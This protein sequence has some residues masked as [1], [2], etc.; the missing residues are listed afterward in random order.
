MTRSVVFKTPGK[1]D[2]RSITKF[3][4]NAKPATETPIGYFGTGLKYAVAILA[5][6]RIPMTFYIDG[7]KWTIDIQETQFRGKA[8]NSLQ[9]RHHSRFVGGKTIDLP[10]TTELGKTWEI[11]Q[12]FRELESNTRDEKGMTLISGDGDHTAGNGLTIFNHSTVI[13]V[14][15]EA[16]VQEYLD[17]NKTFLPDGLTQREGSEDVQVF[18]RPSNCIYYRSI[19]VLDLEESERSELTY[20][21]LRDMELTEDRTLK[22]KWHAQYYIANAISKKTD[23]AV[24][25][26]VIAAPAKTFEHGLSFYDPP[27]KEFLDVVE[28]TPVSERTLYANATHNQYRPQKVKA[29]DSSDWLGE[30]IQA[31]TS[32]AD[33]DNT[34]SIISAHKTAILQ[35]LNTAYEQRRKDKEDAPPNE[36]DQIA[37]IEATIEADRASAEVDDSIPF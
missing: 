1:L 16:F 11:W 3:G 18:D 26:K 35:I 21:I 36:T 24:L 7:K 31:V 6:H 19:R 17:R 9:L 30:L 14:E 37:D 8:F 12:A 15:S 29:R 28:E 33:S 20:N 5:R 25:K 34:L 32:E 4:L 27:T 2:L 22:S 23:S 13:V 10:F